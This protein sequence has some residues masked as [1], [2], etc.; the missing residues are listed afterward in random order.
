MS[1]DVYESEEQAKPALRSPLFSRIKA[2]IPDE[3]KNCSAFPHF[4]EV[5]RNNCIPL[6]SCTQGVFLNVLKRK[7]NSFEIML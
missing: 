4:V 1:T 7:E 2:W 6:D 5:S 3:T